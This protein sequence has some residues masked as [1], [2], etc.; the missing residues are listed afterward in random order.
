[1][2]RHVLANGLRLIH[3]HD[4]ATRM[5]TVDVMYNVG[6]K[7]EH[8]DHTGFA[9]LFEHLMFAGSAHVPDF[10]RV[11]LEASGENNAWTSADATNYYITLPA[12]HLE[13]ALFLEADRMRCLS[14][15]ARRLKVQKQV[16]LEEFKQR[17]LNQPYG[18]V[19]LL[20]RPLMYGSHPYSWPTI[21]KCLEHIQDFSLP[22]VEDFYH[23]F[24][25][26]DN[27]VLCVVGNV[28]FEQTVEWVEKWFGDIPAGH[29]VPRCLPR[30]PVQT[31][32]RVLSV[33]R[34]VPV[35]ALYKSWQAPSPLEPG[36]LACDL[37]TDVLAG[38]R[39]SRL[40]QRLVNQGHVFDALDIY[41]GSE[42]EPSCGTIQFTG[43]P[44]KGVSLE[45]ADAALQEELSALADDCLAA[46]RDGDR[47]GRTTVGN[48]CG[49]AETAAGNGGRSG[50]AIAGNESG[51][52]KRAVRK[53][54][55]GK[56]TPRELQK[57]K[58]K[59]E[60][61]FLFKN[62]N[63]QQVASQMC[64]Y[65]LLGKIAPG[66][67]AE[68]YWADVDRTLALGTADLQEMA[69]RTFRPENSCALYYHSEGRQA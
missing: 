30:I 44:A 9:H 13:T 67:G 52:G 45:Q 50:S 19:S 54:G 57:V 58:N 69:R 31:Q 14:L 27:A 42:L 38:G 2:N 41:L 6:S 22:D 26:P 15:D 8:P 24:Y 51:F 59:F 63:H 11:V 23:R 60:S 47:I 10:D 4:A 7:D 34:D 35:S 3:L 16:V 17:Y 56:I 68:D 61:G 32:P 62:T 33:S 48:G 53:G 64:M 5:A 29:V 36:Y 46:A 28:S 39:S 21:G 20:M 55:L 49:F 25:V 40:T 1:M 37:L 12:G 43:K 66:H 18:D 65:E